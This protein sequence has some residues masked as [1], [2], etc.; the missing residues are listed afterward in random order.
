MNA[1]IEAGHRQ[2]GYVLQHQHAGAV[3]HA[4]ATR[5]K[6]HI[7]HMMAGAC[8]RGHSAGV[9]MLAHGCPACSDICGTR[10]NPELATVACPNMSCRI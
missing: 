3:Q 10:S 4:A 8:E 1:G 9:H 5:G 7:R 6:G 2:A